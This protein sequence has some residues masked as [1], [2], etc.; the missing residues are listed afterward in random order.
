MI[1][2][3]VESFFSVA[4][5]NVQC[6]DIDIDKYPAVYGYLKTK[7]MVNGVPAILC[8]YKGNCKYI[9]DDYVLGADKKQLYD[10]FQRCSDYLLLE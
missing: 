9:P 7:K 8:Y 4:P 10:F 5:P 1:K 2:K 3:D 6:V